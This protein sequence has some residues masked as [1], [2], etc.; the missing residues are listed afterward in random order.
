MVSL[1]KTREHPEDQLWDELDRVHAGLFGVSGSQH[2]MQP[3]SPQCD[4]D[5]KTIWFFTKS[6]VDFMSDIIPGRIGTFCLVG[7][8]HDYYATLTGPLDVRRDEKV[9]DEYWSPMVE[10]WYDGGKSDPTLV[11]IEMRVQDA[12]IWASTSNVIKLGWEVAKATLDDEKTPDV[13][14]QRH[15]R[16]V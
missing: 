15:L 11:L 10:A 4:R 9:I 8:D 1:S 13:G 16:L 3:M 7:K 12:N 14:V 2:P 5:N 6:S